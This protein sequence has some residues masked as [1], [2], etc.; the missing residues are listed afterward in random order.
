M[1]DS[2][3]HFFVFG[4]VNLLIRYYVRVTV[5]DE[6][7]IGEELG[8]FKMGSLI[9]ECNWKVWERVFEYEFTFLFFYI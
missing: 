3:L 9:F 7:G 8:E 6:A 2:C 4:A 5:K 1:S